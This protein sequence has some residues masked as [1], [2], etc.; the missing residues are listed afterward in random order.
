M[1]PEILAKEEAEGFLT[2]ILP[3]LGGR[4]VRG[5]KRS[6]GRD[7]TPERRSAHIVVFAHPAREG[8]TGDPSVHNNESQGRDLTPERRTAHVV[9]FCPPR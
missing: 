9:S 3:K 2:M 1:R 4:E 8:K 6:Q 5:S 7:F